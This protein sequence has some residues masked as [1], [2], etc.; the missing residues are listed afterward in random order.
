MRIQMDNTTLTCTKFLAQKSTLQCWNT[1]S[2]DQLNGQRLSDMRH[3]RIVS[4]VCSLSDMQLVAAAG[5]LS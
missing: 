2:E 3:A 1:A 5:S 4:E